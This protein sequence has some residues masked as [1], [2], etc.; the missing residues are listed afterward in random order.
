MRQVFKNAEYQ[1]A[2]DRDGF[3][4]IPFLSKEEAA[5]LTAKYDQLPTVQQTGFF[6]GLFSESEDFKRGCHNLLANVARKFVEEYLVDYRLL[7]GSFVVKMPEGNSV[8]PMHQDWT[9]VDESKYAS[10][11]L[12]CA[13]TDTNKSNGAMHLLRGSHRLEH[14]IRGTLLPASFEDRFDIPYSEL[15]YVPLEAGQMLVHDHRTGHSSPPNRTKERRLAT[16]M[17]MVPNEAQTIHYY[18]NPETNRVEVYEIDTEFFMKHT[19][20]TNR[21]PEGT[22]FLRY[23]DNYRPVQFTKAAI[24]SLKEKAAA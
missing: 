8:M 6:T 13:L 14:N 17:C 5:E 2:F 9:F 18:K 10:L 7:V 19:Y 24:E 23:E 4:A 21:I 11:N 20:G 1:A 16:A 12:W 15:A 22:R 3:V